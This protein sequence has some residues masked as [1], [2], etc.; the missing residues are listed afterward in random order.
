MGLRLMNVQKIL[1]CHDEIQLE[2][3]Q[4]KNISFQLLELY[5]AHANEPLQSFSKMLLDLKLFQNLISLI[6]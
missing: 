6:F 5:R 4:Q 3:R 2:L 1:L